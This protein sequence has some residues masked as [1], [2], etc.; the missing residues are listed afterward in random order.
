M[1]AVVINFPVES[2]K[3]MLGHFTDLFLAIEAY[4]DPTITA[5]LQMPDIVTF[6][7]DH[8]LPRK[9]KKEFKWAGNI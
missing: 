9:E 7:E 5:K 3:L 2:N 8:I 4:S 6:Y 1:D